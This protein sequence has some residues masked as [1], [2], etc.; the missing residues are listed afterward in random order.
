M[1]RNLQTYL[2]VGLLLGAAG[3]MTARAS[4]TFITFS[5]DMSTNLANGSFNPPPPAGTGTDA[6][7]VFGT[8]NGWSGP[9]VQLVQAGTSTVY[10]NSYNDTSDAN[11][12]V[13]NYRFNINGNN[14]GTANYD[15]RAAYLPSTSGASLVLPTSFYGDKGPGVSPTVTFQL[16][17]SQEIVLGHW[18]PGAGDTVDVRGSFNGWGYNAGYVLTHNP[19]IV[20]TNGSVL[21]TNVY[22]LTVPITTYSSGSGLPATNSEQDFKYVED[23]AS[24]WE[25]PGSF[26]ANDAGNRFFVNS[27]NQVLPVVSF[28]DLPFAPLAQVT[29]NVDMSSVI[30]YDPN[31]VPNSVSVWG[32]FNNW[33]N[34]VP[35]TN[36]P[37]PN[38]NV[39]SAVVTMP[40]GVGVICQFRYTNSVVNGW[41]YDY[42]NDRVY[43]DNIGRRVI[44]LPITPGNISTNMPT[45][46]FLDL[47]PGDYLPQATPV[48]F[49]LDMNGAVDMNGHVFNP[50]IDAVYINGMFANGGGY[51]QAWY[52]WSGG[53]NPVSAPDGYQM[54]RLGSTTLYTNTIVMPAGTVVG[55]QYQYGMDPGSFNGGPSQDEAPS[56]YNHIRVIRSIRLNPYV[57]P[58]D[59]FSNTPYQEPLFA[60]GNIYEGIG[61]LGGGNLTVG[62]Q[63]G[64]SVPVSWLGR[65]GA[66]LQVTSNLVSGS[67]LDIPATDGTNLTV[68]VSTPN[69]LM[70]VTNW[71]ATSSSYFR[72]VKP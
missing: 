28:G 67:W 4:S 22:T 10:T 7:Y 56:G 66:H 31:Y 47:A 18:N 61:T 11:G 8:F 40:E 20:V 19:S 21:T 6:V 37:A 69:G 72:L 59:T 55:L 13:V 45:V 49:T 51:P 62:P 3:M 70:S 30:R 68:G 26:N 60:P 15:N 50:A 65:P 34:G 54:V 9:G 42:N 29:L 53:I 57:M 17:M 48:L 1:K 35:L 46:N 25:S 2:W 64:G 32:T 58:T 14:E 43:D 16:D 36:N 63:V 27:T 71:P 44:T 5:V 24:S 38:T 23:P 52:Q 41:V 12:K 33:A 39:F